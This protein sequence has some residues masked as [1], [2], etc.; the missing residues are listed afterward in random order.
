LE[1]ILKAGFRFVTVERAERYLGVEREGFVALLEPTDGRIKPFGQAGYLMGA[2][3]GMLVER[4]E[5][6]C[7]VWHSQSMAATPEILADYE[8]FKRELR[9]IL[10]DEVPGDVRNIKG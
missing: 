8:N 6:K 9:K 1:R 10:E 7:F 2:G 3:I 4:G 5:S